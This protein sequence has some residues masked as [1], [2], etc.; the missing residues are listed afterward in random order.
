[1]GHGSECGGK[2]WCLLL[3]WK[4][5]KKG[6][7]KT[8]I[9]K[10]HKNKTTENPYRLSLLPTSL[11][12]STSLFS[13]SPVL[14]LCFAFCLEMP[15]LS[16][17]M[18]VFSSSRLYVKSNPFMKLYWTIPFH[19]NLSSSTYAW[20]MLHDF[21]LIHPVIISQIFLKYLNMN[22]ENILGPVT[23]A[24]CTSSITHKC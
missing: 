16:S 3:T 22:L 14:P 11:H 10:T 7:A 20:S 1:M 23:F 13:L 4:K 18:D 2:A 12:I 9:K 21:T 24:L 15:S 17:C 5:K 19:R 6:K 8:Q